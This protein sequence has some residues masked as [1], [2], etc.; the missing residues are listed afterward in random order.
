M[1][2]FIFMAVVTEQTKAITF[3]RVKSTLPQK[4]GGVTSVTVYVWR[5]PEWAR[6]L[7]GNLN[8]KCGLC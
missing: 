6:V 2:K 7:S 1:D 3:H 4:P 5:W 8:A